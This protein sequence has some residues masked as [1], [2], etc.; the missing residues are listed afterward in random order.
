M[1]AADSIQIITGTLDED[2][3][4]RAEALNARALERDGVA[5]LSEQS[6]RA[7]R[8]DVVHLLS[9]HGYANIVVPS[10]GAPMIEMVVDPEHRSGGE[11]GALLQAALDAGAGL[12]DEEPQVWAH[13]DLPPAAA[14]ANRFGMT[15]VRNLLQLRRPLTAG[16]GDPLPELPD[17]DDVVLR[18]YQGASDDAEILRVNNAAFDWHPEQ[19]G[20]DLGQIQDRVDSD[21]FDPGGVFLAFDAADAADAS[22]G[23]TGGALLGFHWTKVHS[24]EETGGDPLGE[25]YI[26]GVDPAAQGR[27]LGTLLTLAGLHHL[28]EQGLPEVQLYVEG[29][30]DAALATYRG[31][32]FER[33]AVDA[34]YCR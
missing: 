26:V 2:D 24:A 9:D 30:N 11:G 17:R 10:G 32:G 12:G 3:A 33:Y 8:G 1:S 31:L 19:G 28:D 22:T 7:V 18:T 27:G 4:A 5:A 14:I 15:R 6:L 13:G 25:V 34:A 23:S 21:W 20:W 16:G 29:D